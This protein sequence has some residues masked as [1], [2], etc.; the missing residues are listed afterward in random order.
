M[1]RGT[2]NIAKSQISFL[3]VIIQPAFSAAAS[4]LQLQANIDNI[5]NNKYIFH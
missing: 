4:I 1:D 2:V 5:E 3:D